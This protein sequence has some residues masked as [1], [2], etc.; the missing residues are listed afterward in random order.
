MTEGHEPSDEALRVADYLLTH[1]GGD[2]SNQWQAG[3]NYAMREA[4][5][6]VREQYH[7]LDYGRYMRCPG[8]G[9]EPPHTEHFHGTRAECGVEGGG[10]G[11]SWAIDQ[12]GVF[13]EGTS[14]D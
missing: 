5:R 12:R 8:C 3:H 7:L 9:N 2:E 4:A 10:C 1:V 14:D 6:L 11:D 13:T